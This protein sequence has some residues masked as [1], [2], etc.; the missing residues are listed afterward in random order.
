[1]KVQYHICSNCGHCALINTDTFKIE[2]NSLNFY[3][4]ECMNID[5]GVELKCDDA[6]EVD[7]FVRIYQDH[8]NKC[9]YKIRKGDHFIDENGDIYVKYTRYAYDSETVNRGL[10]IMSEGAMIVEALSELTIIK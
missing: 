7:D 10:G 4:P 1:M 2:D 6:H 3:C 9:F 5:M 8:K